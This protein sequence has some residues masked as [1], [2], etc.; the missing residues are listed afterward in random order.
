M[1]SIS[2][3]SALLPALNKI[4]SP[5]EFFAQAKKKFVDYVKNGAYQQS[6]TPSLFIYRIRRAHRSHTG[7]IACAHI[8]DYLEGKIK[9][10]ENTLAAKEDK[11]LSLFYDR[12]AMIKPILLTYPNAMEIDAFI[13]RLTISIKPSF[14]IRYDGE[15]HK[16]WQITDEEQVHQL[17]TLFQNHVPASYICDGHHR[18]ASSQ[19]QYEAKKA[20]NPEHNGT[21]SYNYMLSAYFPISE[22]EVHNYNRYVVSLPFSEKEFKEKMEQYFSIEKADKPATPSK[23][24]QVG[25][26]LNKQWYKLDFLPEVVH[27]AKKASVKEQ[28]DVEMLNHLVFEKILGVEDVRTSENILYSEGVL[29]TSNI[30]YLVDQCPKG[31]GF[32]MY[33][34]ALEDLLAIANING[35][36]PPKS[37]WIEPRMCNGFVAQNF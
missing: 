15:K 6:E 22:I 12:N 14:T 19:R 7:I 27:E 35:T 8:E 9:K 2:P 18:A 32:V 26:Y 16:F 20:M 4:S 3:F 30:E 28:L 1:A 34:V 11:M 17:V 10:H 23:P 5:D 33:P 36:M 24:H 31:V 29:G 13:N 37:T 25:M 21:E